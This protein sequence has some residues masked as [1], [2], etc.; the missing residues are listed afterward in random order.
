MGKD[1]LL[2]YINRGYVPGE[3]S[4]TLDF[5]FADYSTAK[6]F[7]YVCKD[8]SNKFVNELKIL[9]QDDCKKYVESAD[10]LLNRAKRAYE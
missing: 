2:D 8:N 9:T 7:Q 10:T 5:G 3:A 1:G 6:A 4:R